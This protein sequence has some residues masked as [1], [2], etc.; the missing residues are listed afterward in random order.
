[1][2]GETET[3]RQRGKGKE[4]SSVRLKAI[5]SSTKENFFKNIYLF[6]LCI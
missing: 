3:E 6:I 1:M 5:S 2:Q 4:E